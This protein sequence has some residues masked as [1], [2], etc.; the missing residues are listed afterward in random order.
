[1]IKTEYGYQQTIHWLKE[2]EAVLEEEKRKYL[3]HQPDK[4]DAI[5]SGTINTIEDLKKQI[6]DYERRRLKKA[7]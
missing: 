1:V 7:G 3:P 5:A 2:F 4:F 6:A